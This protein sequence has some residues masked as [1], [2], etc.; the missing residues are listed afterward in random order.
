[1]NIPTRFGS[2]CSSGLREEDEKQT[3][4][5]YTPLGI[6][7]LL[8]ISYQQKTHTFK[9]PIQSTF[10]PSFVPISPL[11]L[12]KIKNIQNPFIHLYVS[13]FFCVFLINKNTHTHT[14]TL[15]RGQTSEHSYPVWFQ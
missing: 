15:S 6:L 2:N 3:K 7:F 5:F 11:V 10:L 14:H 12:E 4:P 9:G 8:C 13:C 1:M